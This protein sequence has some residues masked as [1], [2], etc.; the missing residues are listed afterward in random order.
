MYIKNSFLNHFE[1]PIVVSIIDGQTFYICKI[2]DET[3]LTKKSAMK[4]QCEDNFQP[5]P[6]NCKDIE[7]TETIKYLLIWL[8][9]KD[10]PFH[11]IYDCDFH[12]F[13]KHVNKDYKLPAESTLRNYFVTFLTFF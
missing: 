8:A 10:I 6:C 2:C 3:Y 5:N 11:A 4:H 13:L 7:K 1:I 12:G 9:K